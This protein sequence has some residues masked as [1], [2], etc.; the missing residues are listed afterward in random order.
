[1]PRTF[2]HLA[3]AASLPVLFA[4]CHQR[5]AAEPPPAIAAVEGVVARVDRDP[6]AYDGSAV[7]DLRTDAGGTVRVHVPARMNL[8]RA[9]G[10]EAFATLAAGARVQVAGEAAGPD[11]IT[12]CAGA[13]HYLRVVAP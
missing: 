2:A 13:S 8:C 1:M 6:W 10:L 12:V 9:Q 3:L 4:A 11:E 5:I 7:M